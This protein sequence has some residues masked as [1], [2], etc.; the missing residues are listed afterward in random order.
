MPT[1]SPIIRARL[2]AVEEIE[3][4]PVSDSAPKM[5]VATPKSAVTTGIPAVSR[6]P[7]VR[8]RMTRRRR[9]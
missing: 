2:C 3:T 1:A 4:V 8:V 6:E 9:R 7:K 5:A